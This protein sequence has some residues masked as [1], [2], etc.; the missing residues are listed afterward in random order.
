MHGVTESEITQDNCVI[1]FNNISASV[2]D[3]DDDAVVISYSFAN[4]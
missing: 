3:Y 4:N 2:G 1:E